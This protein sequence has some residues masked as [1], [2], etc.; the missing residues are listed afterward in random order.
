[1]ELPSERVALSR[2]VE[3]HD[4]Y[5]VFDAGEQILEAD[6]GVLADLARKFEGAQRASLKA[7][8]VFAFYQQVEHHV[9]LR[10]S[11][12]RRFLAKR[13]W[14]CGLGAMPAHGRAS[15]HRG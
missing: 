2:M 1:M 7:Y 6:D 3:L 4:A 13:R 8:I 15:V 10:R 12:C 11:A 9:R 5:A 14:R